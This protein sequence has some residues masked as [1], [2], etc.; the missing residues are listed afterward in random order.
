M[1]SVYSLFSALS[2][3]LDTRI[4]GRALLRVQAKITRYLQE[5]VP[6]QAAII[7]SARISDFS[8]VKSIVIFPELALILSAFGS[9]GAG[10]RLRPQELEVAE[11]HVDLSG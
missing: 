11:D 5:K 9:F 6:I 8:A 3:Q 2:S 10:S 7:L 4:T 1:S